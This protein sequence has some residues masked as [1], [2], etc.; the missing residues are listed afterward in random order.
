[1][2]MHLE[3]V[4]DKTRRISILG[5]IRLFLASDQ[6]EQILYFKMNQAQKLDENDLAKHGS[7]STVSKNV[8]I[9]TAPVNVNDE[10]LVLDDSVDYF[11]FKI[12]KAKMPLLG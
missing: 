5:I 8:S 4:E 10:E 12:S 2:K 9:H 3:K 7:I 1:M 6:N 11:E